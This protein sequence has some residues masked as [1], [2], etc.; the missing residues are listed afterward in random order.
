MFEELKKKRRPEGM[1][2]KAITAWFLFSAIIVVFVFL[3]MNPRNSAVAT[4]GAVAEVNSA[5]ISQADLTEAVETLRRNPFFG[6][7][8]DGE[9]GRQRLR[10]V[11]VQQLVRLEVAA[12][13]GEEEGIFVPDA[14]VR[15]TIVNEPYF[16]EDGRFKRERYVQYLQAV[17]KTAGEFE[18][19][20]RKQHAQSRTHR[21]MVSALT[22]MPLELERE[23]E[24]KKLKL[25]SE[26][27]KIPTENVVQPASISAA[28]VTAFLQDEANAKRAQE[29]FDAH[30]KDEFSKPE[31]VHARH[32]LVKAE[33]GDT[34]AEESALAKIRQIRE[35]LKS[36]DF[37]KVA[38]EV[39]ED[40]GSKDKGGDLGFFERG[41]M[42]PEFED[43][44]FAQK[45]NDISEPVQS[46]FGYHLIQVLEKQ[47]A[48]TTSFAEA[49]EGIARNLIAMDQSAKVVDEIRELVKKGDVA[50]VEQWIKGKGMAWEETGAFGLGDDTVPKIGYN[51]EYADAVAR[52]TPAKPLADK[53]VRQGKDAYVV[54]FKAVDAAKAVQGEEQDKNAMMEK[55]Y[56]QQRVND[57][58]GRWVKQ[59][60]AKAKIVIAESYKGAAL[61]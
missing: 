26:Y 8:D 32:I 16:Q 55:F 15:D 6:M 47:E 61:D 57:V 3:D 42:V 48:K 31:Q 51:A 27:V 12:Q 28:D 46:Q 36:E 25:N 34:K 21:L 58:Y 14:Q 7:N 11:A 19:Q 43:V 10:M 30:K 37:A 23:K 20:A 52:L 60:E 39:T 50:A 29:Y 1:N 56:A 53:L 9:T 40:A 17:R 33:R 18:A 49:R 59:L 45:P 35:R 22:P 4:G 44:A 24:L 2:V 13:A 5:V 41:R 54:R 38:K